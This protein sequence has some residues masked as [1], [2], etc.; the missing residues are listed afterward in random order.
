MSQAANLA[1]LGSNATSNGTIS[2][3]VLQVV[4][5]TLNTTIVTTSSTSYVTTG[6][7]ASITPKFATSKILVTITGGD[8]DNNSSGQQ[9]YSTIYRNSTNLGAGSS[10]QF[11]DIYGASSRVIAP[12]CLQYLDSPATTS[13]TAYTLYFYSGGSPNTVKYNS[14]GGTGV[15]ILQEIAQ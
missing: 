11:S 7:T 15:I 14:Q 3:S 10:Q 8:W 1:A 6:L 12:V 5:A 2:G 9:V 4:Q 13:S